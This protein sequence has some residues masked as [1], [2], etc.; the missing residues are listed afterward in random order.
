MIE[1]L[2]KQEEDQLRTKINGEIAKM[3][4]LELQRF[5]AAGKVMWISSK[6]DLL[7]VAY[8]IHQD[9][10][11]QVKTWTDNQ[12]LAAASDDQAKC[13]VETDATLWT[14]VVKP[15]VLVQ[16]LTV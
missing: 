4:W 15:W 1:E 7:D 16:E 9:N 6:L 2:L 13:W 10:L 14:A 12:Q 8:A 5:F 11:D 3:P